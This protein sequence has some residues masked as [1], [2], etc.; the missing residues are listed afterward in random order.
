MRSVRADTR[1]EPLI[2]GRTARC[3]TEVNFPPHFRARLN[4]M[5]NRILISAVTALALNA[6]DGAA[7]AQQPTSEQERAAELAAMAGAD[8][9]R[10]MKELAAI[11]YRVTEIRRSFLGRIR[12]IAE[13]DEFRREIVISS[14]TGEIKRD[15][16]EARVGDA[17]HRNGAVGGGN[18]NGGGNVKTFGGS[19]NGNGNFGGGNGNSSGGNGNSGGGNGNSGGGNGNSGGGNGGNGKGK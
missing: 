11:D 9:V 5:T 7:K 3:E 15:T 10:I 17:Q 1:S 2:A 13:N 16:V 12:I 18:A 6:W 4:T 14:S 8:A 19:G